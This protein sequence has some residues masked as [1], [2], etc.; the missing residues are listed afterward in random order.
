MKMKN[1]ISKNFTLTEFTKSVTASNLSID[2]TPTSDAYDNICYLCNNLLQPLRDKI[3]QPIHINSGYRSVRLNKAV[4]GAETSQHCTGCAAD[5]EIIGMNNYDLACF[6]RD[7]FNFDQ[8]ILEFA[9]NLKVDPNSGWVHVSL[10][11][12]NNRRQCL[13]IKSNKTGYQKG[14]IK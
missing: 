11:K 9:N 3:K 7:N 14:L 13:T 6:I 5:I 10:K 12:E 8:L 1:Q 2:N 4:G